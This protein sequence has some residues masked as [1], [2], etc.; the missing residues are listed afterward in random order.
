M[1]LI[2]EKRSNVFSILLFIQTWVER[3]LVSRIDL[4]LNFLSFKAEIIS[5]ILLTSVTVATGSLVL[6]FAFGFSDLLE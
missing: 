3:L 2:L 5:M 4:R 1:I 6:L